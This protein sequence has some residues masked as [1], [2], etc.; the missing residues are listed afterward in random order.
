M[1]PNADHNREDIHW[2]VTKYPEFYNLGQE[3]WHAAT[4]YINTNNSLWRKLKILRPVLTDELLKIHVHVT[5]QTSFAGEFMM[6]VLHWLVTSKKDNDWIMQTKLFPKEID[7][8]IIP[9]SHFMYH[10]F[11]T[12]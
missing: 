11:L 8:V 5:E 2:N 3:T 10:I 4:T 7:Q 1:L 12:C 6:F 9:P